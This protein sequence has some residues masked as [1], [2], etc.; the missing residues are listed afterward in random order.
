MLVIGDHNYQNY[1]GDDPL[2]CG[3]EQRLCTVK[4]RDY[5]TKPYGSLGI[6]TVA[7]KVKDGS[8]KLIPISEWADRI[9]DMER[10]KAGAFHN[11]EQSPIGTLDQDGISYCHAFSCVDA[12]MIQREM[13]GLPYVELS[14]SSIGGPITGWRNEGAYIEQDLQQ[15]AEFG[16]C[17]TEFGPMLST[18]RNDFKPGWEKDRLNYRITEWWE[19]EPGNYE[20]FGSCLLG[21]F[22]VCGGYNWWGHAVTSLRLCNT[23]KAHRDMC[24]HTAANAPDHFRASYMFDAFDQDILNSWGKNWG[25]NGVGRLTGSKK[26]PDSWYVIR[27]VTPYSGAAA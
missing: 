25:T 13:Q 1:L 22:T 3:G 5:N 20:M 8:V 4:P 15:G 14:A 18:K 11:W 21:G 19:G 7:D 23:S 17:S 26:R 27:R 6:P 10:D 16:A 24:F 9:S 2:H 12:I